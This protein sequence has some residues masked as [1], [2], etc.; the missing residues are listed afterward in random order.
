MTDLNPI[1]AAVENLTALADAVERFR[2]TFAIS[3]GMRED[4]PNAFGC[5]EAEVFVG[6]L[7]AVGLSEEADDFRRAHDEGEEDEGCEHSWHHDDPEA[8]DDLGQTEPDPEVG[9]APVPAGL[10]ED[11]D[12]RRSGWSPEDYDGWQD[13]PRD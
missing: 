13:V 2:E 4:L 11:H 10:H 9:G 1:T 12:A 8:E 3:C 6:L 5:S 7:D